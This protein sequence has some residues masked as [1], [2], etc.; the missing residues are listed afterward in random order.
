MST[1]H[2][3]ISGG[4][5]PPRAI[6]LVLI[7]VFTGTIFLSALLLF[8]VQPM[9][10]KM[11]LPLLGGSPSCGRWRWCSSRRIVARLCLRTCADAFSRSAPRCDRVSLCVCAR[12]HGIAACDRERVGRPPSEHAALWLIGL[13]GVSIG[14]PFFA[15]AADAPMLQ[16][17]SRAPA[18][19]RRRILILYGASNLGSF[20]VLLAYPIVIEP[21]LTLRGNPR[22][23]RQVL[24][25]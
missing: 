17:G 14:L 21:F 22:P 8:S 10:A 23:G 6:N 2:P 7:V 9:F 3:L 25:R 20:A 12:A 19:R 15:V 5:V 1:T 11:V 13:F 18:I 4:T 16:G 24:W